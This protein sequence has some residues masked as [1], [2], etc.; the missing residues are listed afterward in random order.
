[1]AAVLDCFDTHLVARIRAKQESGI[2]GNAQGGT[3][4]DPSSGAALVDYIRLR[5]FRCCSDPA[6]SV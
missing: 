6:D 2:E 1:M 3:V 4:A 5:G